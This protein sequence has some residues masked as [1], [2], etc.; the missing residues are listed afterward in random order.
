MFVYDENIRLISAERRGSMMKRKHVLVI[1][2][3]ARF[4]AF[5][6]VVVLLSAGIAGCSVYHATKSPGPLV[7]SKGV[8]TQIC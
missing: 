1:R 3:K 4:I 6:L 2:S 5:I 7:Q 8:H